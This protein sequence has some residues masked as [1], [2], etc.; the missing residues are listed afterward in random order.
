[1]SVQ[2]IQLSIS[3]LASSRLGTLE[4]CLDSVR[5]LLE[6]VPS[7]LIVV[8][9]G[10]DERVRELAGRYTDQIVP[11]D[12]CN[13]FSAARNAGLR[14]A[15][16]EWFLY[17]DDDEWFEDVSEICEF[18]LSGE[19]KKY[20]SAHYIQ[21]NYL[22]WSGIQ[23]SD[24]PA[25]RMAVRRIDTRFQNSI[26][27]QLEPRLNPCKYFQS[28]VHHYGYVM[29]KGEE[30][31]R[32]PSRN[33]PLLQEEI[34]K[35]PEYLKNY[36]QLIKEYM[37]EGKWEEAERCGR[38]GLL[39]CKETKEEG[40]EEWLQINLARVLSQMPDKQRA[41]EE[42]ATLLQ[43]E[44]L[45]ELAQMILEHLLVNL[46][47]GQERYQEVLTY[48]LQ[49]EETFDFM[50]KHPKLWKEQGHGDIG[51]MDVKKAYVLYPSRM[52]AAASALELSLSD[53]AE[54]FLN[55]LPWEE[56]YRIQGFYP[57]FDRWKRKYG[58]RAEELFL[59]LPYES[60]YL[61]LQKVLCREGADRQ[62][63]F[64]LCAEQTE[65]LHIRQQL[66]YEAVQEGWEASGLLQHMDLGA[67]V[68]CA[69]KTVKELPFAELSKAREWEERISEKYPLQGLWMK[70]LVL[71]KQLL[72]GYPLGEE[73]TETLG[74]Y[75]QCT[76]DFY[77]GQYREELLKEEQQY[78]LPKELQF[79]LTAG[80][81]LER[82]EENEM[83]EALRL[84]R[85]AIHGYPPMTGV[86]RELI[87][88]VRKDMD[89][90]AVKAEGEFLQLSLQMKTAVKGMLEAGQY[91]NALSV[92]EQL[93]T[94]LPEDLELLR[95]R[96]GLLRRLT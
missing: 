32:K 84:F 35:R 47:A 50:E 90:P 65:D 42:I 85:Q 2:K 34:E 62:E 91:Q 4:R 15:K 68:L 48:G 25:Y 66:L 69:G 39:L 24:F 64:A 77:K 21:R 88:K 78:L 71:E 94:L 82:M 72:Q 70:R 92:T 36:L 81:A 26:H 60:P 80:K 86:A 33:I 58:T 5:P 61:L 19:Y 46:C 18:F 10:T 27:E 67:F 38:K 52:N 83:A 51:E 12:W 95:I 11:F 89:R 28:Y 45:S 74:A 6:R 41:I 1:M 20:G 7:E 29:D 3:L 76:L 96:Q 73:L 31:G 57:M 9:T 23:Y 55:R 43:G 17:L 22:D 14:L 40:C 13:D 53:R 79:A 87:R 75:C 93:L 8:F 54:F 56:E 37:A 16:G 63:A 59:K 30:S 49:F 44:G